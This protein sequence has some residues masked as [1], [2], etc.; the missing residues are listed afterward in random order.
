MHG[1]A[2]APESEATSTQR[3]LNSENPKLPPPRAKAWLA[4]AAGG[5]SSSP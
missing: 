4:I 1:A 5:N 3:S 2:H